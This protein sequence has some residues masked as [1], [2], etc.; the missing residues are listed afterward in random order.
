[1]YGLQLIDD[2][3]NETTED[4]PNLPS[5]SQKVIARGLDLTV[6]QSLVLTV[7][8]IGPAVP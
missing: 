1:M 4:L 2:R 6:D 8:Y 3:D 7:V 5:P